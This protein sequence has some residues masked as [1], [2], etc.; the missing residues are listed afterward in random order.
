MNVSAICASV[1]VLTAIAAW[2]PPRSSY[3]YALDPQLDC[4]SNA[5]AFIAPLL[6]DQ[7]IDPMPMRVEANSVNAFRPA[8]G[9]N[10][11]AFGFRVY[12]VLGYEH[13]DALFKRG[14]GQP[15]TDSAYGVV[16]IGPTESVEAHAHLAG[17][18]A[19]IHQVVP[20]LLTAIFCSG[21]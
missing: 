21:T 9:R 14:E 17:S 20:L 2:V 7:Y 4:R 5:H 6:K 8:H 18:G 19:A 15:V 16:V 3:A 12:A 1:T 11:T 13:D 10:L